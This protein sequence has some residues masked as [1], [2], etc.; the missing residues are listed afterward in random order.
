MTETHRGKPVMRIE[1][2]IPEKAFFEDLF[3][4]LGLVGGNTAGSLSSQVPPPE[5]AA[6][7]NAAE[8]RVKTR[9][10]DSA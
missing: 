7:F 10:H 1:P 8:S 5:V 4:N 6:C 2:I 3:Y 9:R